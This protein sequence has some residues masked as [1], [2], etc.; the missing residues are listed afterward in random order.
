[1][2]RT[3]RLLWKITN[4]FLIGAWAV[5]SLVTGWFSLFVLLETNGSIFGWFTA[6]FCGAIAAFM[7]KGS[8]WMFKEL[9]AQKPEKE[10]RRA[11]TVEPD[12]PAVD[13]AYSSATWNGPPIPLEEQI[14]SLQSAGLSLAPQRTI[15]DLLK[16]WPRSDYENDPYGLLLTVYGWDLEG[17][18]WGRKICPRGGSLDF[19]CIEGKG[20]YALVFNDLL[21]IQGLQNLISDLQ[22]DFDCNSSNCTI[23]YKI[24][25][26]MRRIVALINNDW[27]DPQAVVSFLNDIETTVD[28][29]HHFWVADNGQAISLF[30]ITDD[31]A[32]GINALRHGILERYTSR[33][34]ID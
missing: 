26:D 30:F 19:E 4:W 31:D 32:D 11:P 28:D 22:D 9:R 7:G 5:C 25:G 17:K 6:L 23:S 16:T 15:S 21:R 33:Q 12:A 24:K 13:A 3:L 8:W 20:S 29:G 1:M 2:K 10:K 18:P 34:G 14:E 27:A